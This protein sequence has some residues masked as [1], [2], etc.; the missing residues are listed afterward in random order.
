[1]IF[2]TS[3]SMSPLRLVARLNLPNVAKK[4]S[5]LLSAPGRNP[6][7]DHARTIWALNAAS[8]VES[9]AGRWPGWHGGAVAV[10]VASMHRPSST[11]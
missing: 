2:A 6:C 8:V 4:W 9:L 5:W 1:M 11:A 3:A 10:N 7:I